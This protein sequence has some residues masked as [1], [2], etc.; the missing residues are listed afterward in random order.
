MYMHILYQHIIRSKL[1]EIIRILFLILTFAISAL[2]IA[3]I[4]AI[5][6]RDKGVRIH[7]DIPPDAGK[8]IVDFKGIITIVT[9]IAYV[10]AAAG[11]ITGIRPFLLTGMIGSALFAGF[12][13]IEL[14]LWTSRHPSVWIGFATFGVHSIITGAY[15]LKLF[16]GK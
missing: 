9:G 1:M 16:Q 15:C 10:F 4:H 13:L 2:F 12:Y 8:A 14:I 6:N 5:G 3:A 11:I 7:R